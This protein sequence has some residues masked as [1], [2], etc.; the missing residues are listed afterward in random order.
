MVFDHD[1]ILLDNIGAATPEQGVGMA[2][3]KDGDK[4]DAEVFSLPNN[5]GKEE[6]QVN[7]SFSEIR[8]ALFKA[9]QQPPYNGDWIEEIFEDEVVFA[10]GDELLKVSYIIT[11]G[12]AMITGIPLP[13][14]KK[15]E[16]EL[17]SN[18]KGD[19]MRDLLVNALKAAGI[20]VNEDISD[21]EL[22]AKYNQL[23]ANQEESEEEEEEE[24]SEPSNAD[25]ITE[26]VTNALK[27]VTDKLTD[28]ENKLNANKDEEVNKYASIIGNSD[29]YPAL[30]ADDAKLLPL[31]KLKEMAANCQ[32]AYGI[33]GFNV[34]LEGGNDDQSVPTEMPE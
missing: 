3:N 23:Q 14:D 32:T 22:L 1:A 18:E 12:K 28:L 26:A 20:T 21:D 17:K 24:P 30:T 6:P 7:E 33:P 10:I 27:P 31:D 5:D 11:D 19:A 34:N 15:V 9:I 4:I 25:A 8:E 29:K 13:V 16:Y 2:V